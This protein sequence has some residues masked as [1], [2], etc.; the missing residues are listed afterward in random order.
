MLIGKDTR[1]SGYMLRVRAG[2]WLQLRRGRGAVR[3][4][5]HTCCG[6]PDAGPARQLGWSSAPATTLP[7]QRH[8]ILSAPGANKPDDWAPAVGRRWTMLE[9]N[10]Q[11]GLGPSG[12][13][14]RLDDAAGRYIEF[15]KSTFAKPHAASGLIV[16]DARSHGRPT[17]SRPKC[18]TSWAQVGPPLAARSDGLITSTQRRCHPPT[19]AGAR[20]PNHAPTTASRWTAMPTACTWWDATGPPVR[21]TSCC[22]SWQPTAHG[23]GDET[24]PGRGGHADDQPGV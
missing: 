23:L 1:I 3:P 4:L 5:A 20:W 2:V 15:C 21:A 14:R 16:V 18:S 11:G 19:G 24:S 7:R 13:S 12:Q 8:Q 17:T 10:P 22:T 9:Q 6:L